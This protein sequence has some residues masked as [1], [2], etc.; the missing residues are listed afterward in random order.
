MWC[1]HCSAILCFISLYVCLSLCLS[2]FL[3]APPSFSLSFY[4]FTFMPKTRGKPWFTH[5]YNS[6]PPQTTATNMTMKLNQHIS[7]TLSTNT[8]YIMYNLPKVVDKC[9]CIILSQMYLMKS[10]QFIVLFDLFYSGYRNLSTIRKSPLCFKL[11][12]S[13]RWTALMSKVSLLQCQ[14]FIWFSLHYSIP[15]FTLSVLTL[16]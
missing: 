10:C 5:I 11:D 16:S 4:S 13:V 9:K 3:S 6:A 15:F 7:D 14:P 1:Q 8:V 2:I 12:W